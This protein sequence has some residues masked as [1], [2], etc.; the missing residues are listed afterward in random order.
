MENQGRLIW[1]LDKD[2]IENVEYNGQG[3]KDGESSRNEEKQ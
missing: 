1:I 3:Q 2:L